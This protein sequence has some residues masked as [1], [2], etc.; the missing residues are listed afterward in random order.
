MPL[1]K[2]L[3]MMEVILYLYDKCASA[4]RQAGAD[5]PSLLDTGLFDEL[6]KMK[7][8]MP[9]RRAREV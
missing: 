6:V 2:Q 1:E 9:E 8:D 7:Y 3:K 5:Q 4:G